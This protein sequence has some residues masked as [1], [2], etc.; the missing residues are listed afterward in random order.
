MAA[1]RGADAHASRAWI[2]VVA[3]VALLAA[4]I[5]FIPGPWSKPLRGWSDREVG[6]AVEEILAAETLPK[7]LAGFEL[8]RR[9]LHIF[10]RAHGHEPLWIDANGIRPEARQLLDELKQAG[11]EGLNPAD[12][13]VEAIETAMRKARIGGVEDPAILELMLSQAYVDYARDLRQGRISR[14]AI[15]SEAS[16][17][18][19]PM[20]TAAVLDDAAD[21]PSLEDHIDSLDELN[22]IY[23]GLRAALAKLRGG[24]GPTPVTIPAGPTLK[25]GDRDP[26]VAALRQRLKLPAGGS[27]DVY[28]PDVVGAVQ[29]FQR[30][31]GLRADGI[32]G[33]GTLAYLNAKPGN[34]AAVII[35]NMERARWLPADLGD[36]YLLVDT[37]GFVLRMYEN[38][39]Q[40]DI[41]RIV[42]G[43]EQQ[44]TPLMV[45]QME[46][47]E[48][49]PCWNVPQSIIEAEIA[50]KVLAQGPGY[51]ASQNMEVNL[52]WEMDAPAIDPSEVDWAAAQAGI[53]EFRVRQRPGP[54]NSLGLVKFMFPNEHDVYLHDT[55]ADHLFAKELRVFS[56][57][58]VRV[59]R[60]FDLAAW[61]LGGDIAPVR[62]AIASGE[63]AQIQLPKKLPV[64]ITY[65]TAWPRGDGTVEFRP[66]I[67][68]RDRAMIGQLT[69]NA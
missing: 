19:P 28:G 43:K 15:Y 20:T 47:I 36:K 55:P 7:A 3:G 60:P 54:K 58:C 32:L 1:S 56:H 8:D 65:F 10:Y 62:D 67:Y 50:P 9:G 17:L 66:D 40:A 69:A 26:R 51:L 16:M 11:E 2:Y 12:Y 25:P 52:S 39:R 23:A 61:V 53:V 42:V 33:P 48:A 63:T 24:T 35:A 34:Q 22:P 64:Y 45:E 30:S 57:G 49:N 4:L 18:P 37:A 38:G 29:A 5:W 59:E 27:P 13:H 31:K 6:P 46:Y 44:R 68:G 41:M 14:R 21:A